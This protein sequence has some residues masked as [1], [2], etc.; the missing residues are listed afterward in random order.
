MVKASEMES[1]D[2][3]I[4]QNIINIGTYDHISFRQNQKSFPVTLLSLR[5]LFLNHSNPSFKN[6]REWKH[7]TQVWTRKSFLWLH[8]NVLDRTNAHRKR[9]DDPKAYNDDLTVNDT[10]GRLTSAFL[11]FVGKTPDDR[12]FPC[13]R[14]SW[15]LKDLVFSVRP[16]WSGTNR[17]NWHWFYLI[18]FSKRHRFLRWSAI[19]PQITTPAMDAIA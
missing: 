3:W 1:S 17:E 12:G 10:Q 16:G 13:F 8:F 19:I 2:N 5:L 7:R 9:K 15:E 4:L 18:I 11:S 14:A 6:K